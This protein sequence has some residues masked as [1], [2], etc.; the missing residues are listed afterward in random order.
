[1]DDGD[2]IEF[3]DPKWNIPDSIRSVTF[4]LTENQRSSIE[5]KVGEF[6]VA[7]T[8]YHWGTDNLTAPE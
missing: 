6:D 7:Q 8:T 2:E 5:G 3:F 4:G 1:M